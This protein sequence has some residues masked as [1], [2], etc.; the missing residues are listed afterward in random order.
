[1][2]AEFLSQGSVPL[3]MHLQKDGGCPE[4]LAETLSMFIGIMSMDTDIMSMV[5]GSPH[6]KTKRY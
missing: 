4:N 1:M 5:S 6:S 2:V 3:L